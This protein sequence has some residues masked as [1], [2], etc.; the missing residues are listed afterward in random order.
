V[1]LATWNWDLEV[2]L[3]MYLLPFYLYAMIEQKIMK[4]EKF[5]DREC[6]ESIDHNQL[7]YSVRRYM[8]AI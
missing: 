1:V 6:E 2:G 4:K 8:V 7:S 3:G 5:L